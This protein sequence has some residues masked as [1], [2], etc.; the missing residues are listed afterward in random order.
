MKYYF[1]LNFD[2]LDNP[3]NFINLLTKFNLV[4]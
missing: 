4:N 1:H 3:K 2:L